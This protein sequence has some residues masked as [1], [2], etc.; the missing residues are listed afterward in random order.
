MYYI[1]IYSHYVFIAIICL[2]GSKDFSEESTF[3]VLMY[4]LFLWLI[5]FFFFFL[6]LLYVIFLYLWVKAVLFLL[7]E[8]VQC[9]NSIL[10]N[11]IATVS[12][13]R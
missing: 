6:P 10:G 2:F 4:F 11:V 12:T 3:L 9:C 1:S 5:F 8:T 13:K 7:F